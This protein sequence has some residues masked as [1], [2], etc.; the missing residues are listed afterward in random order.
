MQQLLRVAQAASVLNVSASEVY[1]LVR[2][3]QLGCIR[4]GASI[5]FVPAQL[6]VF[7]AANTMPAG[8]E[9]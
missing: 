3:G 8:G 4:V 2:G 1:K 9:A 5:R 7:I 6:D